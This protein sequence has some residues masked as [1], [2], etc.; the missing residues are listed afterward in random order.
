MNIRVRTGTEEKKRNEKASDGMFYALLNDMRE[1]LADLE[2][3]MAQ[4]YETLQHR[5]GYDVVGGMETEEEK[6]Q[7]LA[8]NFLNEEGT[9]KDEY[10]NTEKA[11]YLRD[12]QETQKLHPIV[13]K[14]E[15]RNDLTAEE[16]REA[17]DTASTTSLADNKNKLAISNN[18]VCDVIDI[19]SL[20]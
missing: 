2:A 15:G 20:L 16:Q 14:Y 5:Y 11:K 10:K 1:H 4:R 12:W 6:M 9:N 13:Q 7:A 8:D 18:Q 17:Y 19:L 3:N